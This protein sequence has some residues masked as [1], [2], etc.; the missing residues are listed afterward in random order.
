MICKAI[1]SLY[2]LFLSGTT[3]SDQTLLS[4][5]KHDSMQTD[6][7]MHVDILKYGSYLRTDPT[8]TKNDSQV[9]IPK[10]VQSTQDAPNPI[11]A[12]LPPQVQI[13]NRNDIHLQHPAAA[14]LVEYNQ[15]SNRTH[16]TNAQADQFIAKVQEILKYNPNLPGCMITFS[17]NHGQTLNAIE[18][19][20]QGEWKVGICGGNQAAVVKTIE[21]KLEELP[22][23][24]RRLRFAPITTMKSYA[25]GGSTA[26]DEEFKES[27]Q[28]IQDEA[29]AGHHI[30][31]WTNQGAT[32]DNPFAVGG[33]IASDKTPKAHIQAAQLFLKRLTDMNMV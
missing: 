19:Y 21:Q 33:S 2:S 27:L 25:D 24:Q 30:I 29:K 16:D 26:S 28:F 8:T 13:P 17:A 10:A 7:P 23:L 5:C 32:K 20:S 14:F 22:A 1:K 6:I 31:V 3:C 15:F 12:L 18:S 4:Q 9:S 11:T